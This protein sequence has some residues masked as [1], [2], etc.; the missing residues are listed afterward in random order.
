MHQMVR[1]AAGDRDAIAGNGLVRKTPA[2]H[3]ST[4]RDSGA[5]TFSNSV[6]ISS[7]EAVAVKVRRCRTPIQFSRIVPA[8]SAGA[9]ETPKRMYLEHWGLSRSPFAEGL[10]RPLFYEGES[11]SE[12][13]ARLRFVVRQARRLA[14]LVGA[15][16]VGKS[17]LMRQFADELRRE[18]RSVALVPLAGLSVRELFWQVA[19]QLSL[20]PRPGEDAIALFRRLAALG[21]SLR[22][23]SRTATLLFDEADQAGADVRAQLVRLLHLGGDLPRITLVVSAIPA[24][25]VRLAAEVLDATDLRIE[26]EPWSEGETVGY[27]QHA[28][29]EAGC[30]RPA[31]DDAAL[32]AVAT[33]SGGVPRQVNRLADHALLIA[34]GEGLEAVNAATIDAAHDALNWVA[35]V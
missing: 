13:E 18:G 24:G 9:Q 34:A 23:E 27:V 4:P 25:V 33:L 11:Q 10:A 6:H 31:F 15:R 32:A 12:A 19:A 26:L 5:S 30:D 22:W 16:G 29:L 20:G 1:L 14:V 7:P 28:L 17:L 35:A 3:S 2:I 8:N 21:D